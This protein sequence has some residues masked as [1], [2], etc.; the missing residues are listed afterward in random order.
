V[1][2][3]FLVRVLIDDEAGRVIPGMSGQAVFRLAPEAGAVTV[4]KD[5][6]VRGS[7]GAT[8]LWLATPAGSEAGTGRVSARVVTLGRAE[9]GRIEIRQGLPGGSLVVVRGNEGLR[10]G[11]E[12]RLVP[13]DRI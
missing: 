2:R 1:S 3:T 6:V 9:D 8:R 13:G 10:E 12:V 7:D 5:A 4:P 11:Q